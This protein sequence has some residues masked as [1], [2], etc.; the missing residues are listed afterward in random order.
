MKQVKKD[1]GAVTK[2]LKKLSNKIGQLTTKLTKTAVGELERAQAAIRLKSPTQHAADA[3]NVLARQTDKLIKTVNKFEK[4]KAAK[5]RTA[6]R[7]PAREAP[8]KKAAV[9]KRVSKKAAP[10]TATDQ[11]LG[12]IKRSKKGVDVPTLMKKTGYDRKKITDIVYRASKQGRIKR[13]GKGVYAAS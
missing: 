1:L 9:K 10:L 11:V 2:E 4:G 5:R 12:V 13:V 3:L 7:K 8:V 6:K